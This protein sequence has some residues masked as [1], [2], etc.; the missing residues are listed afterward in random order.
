MTKQLDE[1]VKY[2]SETY[3]AMDKAVRGFMSL[4]GAE[5]RARLAKVDADNAEGIALAILAQ[6]N[7]VPEKKIVEQAAKE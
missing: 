3:D 4:D 2:L 5:I 6:A 7:P 1:A